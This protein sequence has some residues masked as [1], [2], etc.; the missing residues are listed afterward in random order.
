MY[1]YIKYLKLILPAMSFIQFSL[2]NKI[3]WKKKNDVEQEIKLEE[4]LIQF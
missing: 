3:Q 1:V 2:N 4:K